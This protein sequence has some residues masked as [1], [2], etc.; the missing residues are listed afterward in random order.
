MT[1][2]ISQLDEESEVAQAFDQGYDAG[3]N[4]ALSTHGER[5]AREAADDMRGRI[6]ETIVALAFEGPPSAGDWLALAAYLQRLMLA[7]TALPTLDSEPS[8]AEIDVDM[9]STRGA[10]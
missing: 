8:S 1:I 4:D 6:L 7:I 3:W 2:N 10:M 5:Q 9:V